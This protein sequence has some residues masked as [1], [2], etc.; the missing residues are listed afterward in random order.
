MRISRILMFAPAYLASHHCYEI[1][2]AAA[3]V[4]TKLLQHNVSL[5]SAVDMAVMVA[6]SGRLPLMRNYLNAA[7]L[8]DIHCCLSIRW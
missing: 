2:S 1:S 7:A 3:K 8:P 4:V 5:K 6:G